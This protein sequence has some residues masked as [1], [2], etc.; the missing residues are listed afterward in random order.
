TERQTRSKD[1]LYAHLITESSESAWM[2]SSGTVSP[3]A[4]SYTVTSP[5]STDTPKSR[6]SKS[7]DEAYLYTPHFFRSTSEKV[8]TSMDRVWIAIVLLPPLKQAAGV[9]FPPP[10]VYCLFLRLFCSLALLLPVLFKL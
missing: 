9:L 10:G 2:I 8:S 7:G 3:D 1:A 4:R 6:I 5:P